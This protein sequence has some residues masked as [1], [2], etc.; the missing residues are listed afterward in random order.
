MMNVNDKIVTALTPGSFFNR[1]GLIFRSLRALSEFAGVDPEGLL[2]VL[3]GELAAVVTCKAS[4]KGKGILV[5]LTAHIPE[6]A[7]EVP[8]AE[9]A[10]GN[11]K[12][13]YMLFG[14]Q[15]AAVQVEV[16]QELEFLDEENAGEVP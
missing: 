5:A 12:P 11:V 16:A 13:G 14:D 4:G 2:E 7:Q 6:G 8:D 9:Q 1:K 3:N 15:D 10:P